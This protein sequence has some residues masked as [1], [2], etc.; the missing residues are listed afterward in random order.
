MKEFEK[1]YEEEYRNYSLAFHDRVSA[2]MGWKAALEWVKSITT[3]EYN[4][5][6]EPTGDLI[7]DEEDL[8]KELEE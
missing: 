2:S 3:R 1:W 7:I 4:E 5:Y 8:N 6:D